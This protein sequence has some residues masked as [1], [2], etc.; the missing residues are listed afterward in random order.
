MQAHCAECGPLSEPDFYEVR[1]TMQDCFCGPIPQPLLSM[2]STVLLVSPSAPAGHSLLPS[3]HWPLPNRPLHPVCRALPT[4]AQT[5]SWWGFVFW[6]D[7]G[8][9]LFGRPCHGELPAS[10]PHC[11]SG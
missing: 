5:A 10:S 9:P 2:P 6:G 8:L 1:R 7:A 4:S 3:H 11:L